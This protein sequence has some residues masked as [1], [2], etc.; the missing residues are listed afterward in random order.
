ML[1]K[2]LDINRIDLWKGSILKSIAH[3]INVAH[4]PE[5]SYENSWDGFNYNL[6]DGEGAR[7]TI[8]F[9]P[10]FCIAAFQDLNSERSE[11]VKEASTYFE[12]AS[13]KLKEIAKAETFQYLL[14][15]VEGETIPLITSSFWIENNNAYSMDTFEDL[16]EH[17]GFLL[18]LQLE[19]ITSAIETLEEEYEMTEQQLE[20]LQLI[21]AKKIKNPEERII[22][23]E[24]EVGMMG[25]IDDEGL[26]ES[27]ES[28]EEIN[29]T[30]NF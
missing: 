11:L 13:D 23:S 24:H 25:V 30:W 3:A 8:T 21:F 6:Q 29:V 4:Y 22:L 14:E 10:D 1:K 2:R 17:G 26:K 18:N 5:L 27:K 16:Q 12:E 19:D 7:G 28:F 20:L 15:D 9:H